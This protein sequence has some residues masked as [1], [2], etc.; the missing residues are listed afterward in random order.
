MEAWQHSD[1]A[2]GQWDNIRSNR[3]NTVKEKGA[4]L[5]ANKLL[6]ISPYS[7]HDRASDC[8]RQALSMVKTFAQHQFKVC[9]LNPTIYSSADP[10]SIEPVAATTLLEE[11]DSFQLWDEG[12][13]FIYIRTVSQ[14]FNDITAQEQR[15]LL[16]E[17]T[18]LLVDFKPDLLIANSCD[19]ITL[20]CLNQAKRSHIFTAF[21]LQ[22]A[23]PEF[24]S[25][26]DVDLILSTSHSLTKR[27]VTPLERTASY[28]GPFIKLNGP[29]SPSEIEEL[30][31]QKNTQDAWWNRPQG[32]FPKTPPTDSSCFSSQLNRNKIFQALNQEEPLISTP[33]T[34]TT[35]GI[36]T[37]IGAALNT[38]SKI[39]KSPLPI[40][41][42]TGLK[43]LESIQPIKT[44]KLPEI[45]PSTKRQRVLLVNPD[46][47]HGL[48]IFL[49]LYRYVQDKNILDG[50][51]AK[52]EI[53][54]CQSQQ[55]AQNLE[56]YYEQNGL[57]AYSSEDFKGI[58]V[59]APQND[60]DAQIQRLLKDTQVLILPTLCAVGTSIVALQALSYGV[61]VITTA[62]TELQELL[63][64]FALYID[65]KQ[66]VI[67]N[68]SVVTPKEEVIKW[69]TA[70]KEV[71]TQSVD[72]NNI[73][74]FLQDYLYQAGAYRLILSVMP[75]MEQSRSNEPRLLRNCTFSMRL[76]RK[77]QALEDAVRAAA[78]SLAEPIPDDDDELYNMNEIEDDEEAF[79]SNNFDTEN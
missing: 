47:E 51:G 56:L 13:N 66:E 15:A 60:P 29:L 73:A 48:G 28:I 7:L 58:K 10:L 26:A 77:K 71:F 65:V 49:E 9:V 59:I 5:M 6:W 34:A 52:F 55:F 33:Q 19:V 14:H 78:A 23:I 69:A 36:P 74:D 70:L 46:I 17:L 27:F 63:G 45:V 50:L 2:A 54:E 20:C 72:L 68:L 64:T 57:K 32:K 79:L 25:F 12:V 42:R 22:E 24:F 31:T 39:S 43:T 44:R 16:N 18:P 11:E 37:S 30:N 8:A 21:I 3:E 38:S 61:K 53:L 1:R 40:K 75:L 67:N 62:Q 35:L 76:I 4:A 41:P